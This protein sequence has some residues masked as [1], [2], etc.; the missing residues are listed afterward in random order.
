MAKQLIV[1]GDDYGLCAPVNQAIEECLEAGTMGATCVMTNMPACG[2]AAA[3]RRKFPHSS[4]GLHWNI[5]QGEPLLQAGALP[6]LVDASGQFAG[7]LRH[8]WLNGRIDRAELRAELVAQY[9][10]FQALAGDADFWNTHQNVHV[11]P[12]L[13]QFFVALANELNVRAMRSHERFTVPVQGSAAGYHLRHPAYWLKGQ[14]IRRWSRNARAHGARMPDRRRNMPRFDAG[15]H[16][17]VTLLEKLDWRRVGAAVELVIHP[18][19]AV[20]AGL[21]GGLTESR[22]RE[23]KMFRDPNL[24][25]TLNRAGVGLAGF[26]A[27]GENGAGAGREQAA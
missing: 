4:I 22:L 2:A 15:K 9:R 12:G 26:A 23:Y 3:L 5:T 6:S 16:Q 1:T 13:F 27:I 21:F 25:E 17:L 19:R 11:Y 10:R 14:V 20:D 18:A 24:V 7:P 8:R